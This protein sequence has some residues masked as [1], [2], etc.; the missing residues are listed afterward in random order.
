MV[1]VASWNCKEMCGNNSCFYRLSLLQHWGHF[2]WSQTDIF[3]VSSFLVT[4]DKLDILND[5]I[6]LQ[7]VH[8]F[9]LYHMINAWK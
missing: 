1:Q 3:I 7:F 8:Y 6:I 2:M 5:E 9:G 4:T